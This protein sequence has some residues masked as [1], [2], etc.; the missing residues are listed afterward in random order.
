[1]KVDVSSMLEDLKSEVEL[2]PE[3]QVMVQQVLT[4]TAMLTSRM[5]AG[6]DVDGELALV[7]AT[8]LNLAEAKRVKV[9]S[10]LNQF[11]MDIIG[12]A[13]TAVFAAM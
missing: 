1:M 5:L 3:E 12:K 6:E 7:K 8:A 11:I 2:S 13:M 10:A 4:D 9:Q